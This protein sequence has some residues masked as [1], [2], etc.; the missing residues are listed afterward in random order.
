VAAPRA[1][2]RLLRRYA[3]AFEDARRRSV[4]ES[5]TVMFLTKFFEEV[6]GYDSFAGQI[7]KELAIKDRYCDIALKPDGRTVRV[8]VEAKAVFVAELKDKHIEQA[9]NYA[10]RAGVRW[11]VLTNGIDWRLYHL[12]FAERD[13]I[14]HDLAFTLNLPQ[15]LAGDPVGVWNKLSLLSPSGVKAGALDAFWE[16]RKLLKPASILRALFTQDVLARVR[17]ELNRVAAVRLEEQDVLNAIRDVVTKDALLEAGD[18]WPVRR[19]P[20]RVR[21]ESARPKGKGTSI[22]ERVAFEVKQT[23]DG[24]RIAVKGRPDT[25]E[26][27]PLARLRESIAAVAYGYTEKHIGPRARVGN[28]G[29]TLS[30]RLRDLL[31]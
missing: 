30:N 13:G 8:L 22:S 11:V 7:S 1:K 17:R 18:L 24:V 29:G 6:L 9:A 31:R 28:K 26:V 2:L 14:A 27:V 20:R 3:Q 21:P 25:A 5:D 15:D 4:N 12:T 16:K 19:K 23:S 10:S